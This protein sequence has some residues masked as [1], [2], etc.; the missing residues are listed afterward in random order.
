MN[1]Q[2]EE[3]FQL[4]Y[5]PLCLY[6]IGLIEDVNFA[7]DIVM[8]C[9]VKFWKRRTKNNGEIKDVKSYLY[10][11][12]RHACYDYNRQARVETVEMD[13]LNIDAHTEE[14]ERFSEIAAN[15]WTAIDTLP[16]QCRKIFLMSRRDGLKYSEIAEEL[17]LSVK[18]VE[19]QMGKA[20]KVLRGKAKE[21]Y[22]F[23]LSLFA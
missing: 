21:I 1:N 12:V 5:R 4:Y 7:E 8:D 6:A 15:L 14:D 17:G 19:A 20:Y 10:L 23:I 18:T 2:I 16:A 11:M 9:Y 3:L 13:V 22:F